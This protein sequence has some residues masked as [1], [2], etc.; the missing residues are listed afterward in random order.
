MRKPD[1]YDEAQTFDG[2]FPQLELGGHICV[3]KDAREDQ[4]LSGNPCLRLFLDIADGPQKDFF[5]KKYQGDKERRDDAKWGC[6]YTQLTEGGSLPYFKGMISAV[7]K[8]NPGYNFEAT[9]D[10]KT[11]KGKYIGGVFGR[12]QYEK[13]DGSFG[14]ATK[15]RFLRSTEAIREGVPVPED[16][17]LEAR[18]AINPYGEMPAPEDIF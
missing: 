17:L 7:S 1:G 10:E 9:F 3:I 8:S 12:E 15:C 16:K 11:L 18:N 5:A 4:T 6:V 13:Q 2:N 14:W